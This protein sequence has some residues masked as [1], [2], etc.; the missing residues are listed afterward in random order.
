MKEAV[1]GEVN[2]ALHACETE[3]YNLGL[4]DC[5]DTTDVI[6]N[7]ELIIR[8]HVTS[9]VYNPSKDS[10]PGVRYFLVMNQ[11]RGYSPWL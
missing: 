6:T 1:L 4:I 3:W 8:G 10:V 2:S 11:P 7:N 9:I 5:D